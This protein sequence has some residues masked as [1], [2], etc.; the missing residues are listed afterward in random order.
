MSALPSSTMRSSSPSR[1]AA[2]C[3]AWAAAPWTTPCGGYWAS[4]WPSAG[5]LRP[6]SPRRAP[7]HAPQQI[8]L[9]LFALF[10]STS[11]SQPGGTGP[12]R[13]CCRSSAPGGHQRG[14]DVCSKTS[15]AVDQDWKP[16]HSLHPRHGRSGASLQPG[17]GTPLFPSLCKIW[18]G[19]VRHRTLPLQ[20][21][22]QRPQMVATSTGGPLQLHLAL[23]EVQAWT[24]SRRARR[25]RLALR[26]I[27]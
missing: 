26:G 23:Y 22:C 8:A 24:S 25:L 9:P 2:S 15:A 12:T 21:G 13:L 19:P 27:Q 16:T 6:C 7:S 3:V 10:D 17:R 18:A 20:G 11:D 1:R 14:I 4:L 5:P